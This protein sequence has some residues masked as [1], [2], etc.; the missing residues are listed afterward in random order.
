MNEEIAP[1]IVAPTMEEMIASLKAVRENEVVFR[2]M[3]DKRLKVLMADPEYVQFSEATSK[4][5]KLVDELEARIKTM[6]TYTFMESG[7]RDFGMGILDK[8][9]KTFAIE[10]P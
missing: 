2:E 3:R 4:A 6:A 9:F 10:D 8:D 1:T 5:V 7:K